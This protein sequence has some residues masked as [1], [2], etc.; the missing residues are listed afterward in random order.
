MYECWRFRF[1]T[2][3]TNIRLKHKWKSWGISNIRSCSIQNSRP[4]FMLAGY[5]SMQNLRLE[6][7]DTQAHSSAFLFTGEW[8]FNSM[9][10]LRFKK[11]ESFLKHISKPNVIATVRLNEKFQEFDN[12]YHPFIANDAGPASRKKGARTK[13]C[14]NVSRHYQVFA[15]SHRNFW[16]RP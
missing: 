15:R 13:K 12:V 16:K 6:S 1:R 2:I 11:I 10:N 4:A 8:L 14:I 5:T 7:K 9:Q 3:R